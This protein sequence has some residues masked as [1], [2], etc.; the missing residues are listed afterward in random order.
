MVY[1]HVIE[2]SVVSKEERSSSFKTGTERPNH[3]D[4]TRAQLNSFQLLTRFLSFLPDT[5]LQLGHFSVHLGVVENPRLHVRGNE[6]GGIGAEVNT[7]QTPHVA[8][9]DDDAI[10]FPAH[11]AQ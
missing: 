11:T 6:D 5:L 7:L 10:Q 1:S 2:R 4:Q 3:S 9:H 8:Q